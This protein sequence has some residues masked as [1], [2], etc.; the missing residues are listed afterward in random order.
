M[1]DNEYEHHAPV[2]RGDF[3]PFKNSWVGDFKMEELSERLKLEPVQ[4]ELLAAWLN[5]LEIKIWFWDASNKKD[6]RRDPPGLEISVFWEPFECCVSSANLFD[7]LEAPL[8]QDYLQ[9][10][11]E[12]E[13]AALEKLKAKIDESIAHHNRTLP[14]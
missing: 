8:E 13:I 12:K 4:S 1:S 14:E 7:L 3:Y 6:L 2:V 10:D 9:I 11:N 5:E